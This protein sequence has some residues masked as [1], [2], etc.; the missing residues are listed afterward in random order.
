MSMM[1]SALRH[2]YDKN[3]LPCTVRIGTFEKLVYA[4]CWG[5][6]RAEDFDPFDTVYAIDVPGLKIP[7][8]EH[9]RYEIDSPRLFNALLDK[10]C[11]HVR[12]DVDTAWC[13]SD[14]LKTAMLALEPSDVPILQ[15]ALGKMEKCERIDRLREK[16]DRY[17][18][19]TEPPK[20]RYRVFMSVN[21]LCT[22]DTDLVVEASDPAQAHDIATKRAKT[23]DA[24]YISWVIDASKY[25]DWST[26]SVQQIDPI[27]EG[28]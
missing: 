4:Y 18:A 26:L 19:S 9:G 3:G 27:H 6:H 20:R 7:V 5:G 8:D 13:Q 22:A 15:A 23:D 28:V 21:V 2:L 10:A 14:D 11:L 25:F 16:L 12:N 1:M 17:A 24:P